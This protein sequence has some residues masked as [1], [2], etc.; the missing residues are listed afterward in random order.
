MVLL[1]AETAYNQANFTKAIEFYKEAIALKPDKADL[2]WKLGIAYYSNGDKK[3][4]K[5]Q[6]LKLRELGRNDLANDLEQLASK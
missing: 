2:H 6:V 1:K 5:E 4:F 3:D